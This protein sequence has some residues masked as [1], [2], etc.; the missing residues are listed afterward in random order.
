MSKDNSAG[1]V[2]F[3]R[4]PYLKSGYQARFY[5]VENLDWVMMLLV[6]FPNAKH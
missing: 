1:I 2:Q 5:G 4:P 6:R 3:T